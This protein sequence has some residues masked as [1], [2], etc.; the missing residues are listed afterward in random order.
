MAAALLFNKVSTTIEEFVILQ[1]LAF[2]FP[3]SRSVCVLQL[4]PP[5]HNCLDILIILKCVN[6][7]VIL[8]SRIEFVV[9]CSQIMVVC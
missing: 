2:Q 6:V 8:Y 3:I 9:A 5:H 1:N 4:E 7:K